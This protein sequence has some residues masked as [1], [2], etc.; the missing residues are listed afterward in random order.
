MFA[1]NSLMAD[2]G[3]LSI[4]QI[5]LTYHQKVGAKAWRMCRNLRKFVTFAMII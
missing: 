4:L 3:L 1:H 5:E 2:L